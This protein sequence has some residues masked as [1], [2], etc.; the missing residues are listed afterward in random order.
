MLP[1]CRPIRSEICRS[2]MCLEYYCEPNENCVHLL[3]KTV[4]ITAL[5]ISLSSIKCIA[6]RLSKEGTSVQ[7]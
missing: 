7:M 4:D 3:V 1:D 2:L 6:H 5:V